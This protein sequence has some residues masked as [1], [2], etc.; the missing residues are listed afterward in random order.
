[1]Y[2][3]MTSYI[4]KVFIPARSLTSRSGQVRSNPSR[5][6][7]RG[8]KKETFTELVL[9]TKKNTGEHSNFMVKVI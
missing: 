8:V 5:V 6:Q 7:G 9:L 3:P 1:M 2:S 4:L